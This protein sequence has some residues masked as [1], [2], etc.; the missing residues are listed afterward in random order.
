M[1]EK[2]LAHITESHPARERIESLRRAI[3]DLTERMANSLSAYEQAR[4][5]AGRQAQGLMAKLHEEVRIVHGELQ[6]A[7]T[8][9]RRMIRSPELALLTVRSS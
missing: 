5:E 6:E 8:A 3:H 7:Q 2:R 1:D 4:V 9:W